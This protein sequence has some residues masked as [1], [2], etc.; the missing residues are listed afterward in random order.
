MSATQLEY[1][2]KVPRSLVLL[3]VFW[4]VGTSVAMFLLQ[5][6]D[7]QLFYQDEQQ[8]EVFFDSGSFAESLKLYVDPYV[9]SGVDEVYVFHFWNPECKCDQSNS[10]HVRKLVADYS[11]NTMFFVVSA[12]EHY[13]AYLEQWKDVLPYYRIEFVDYQALNL[14]VDLPATPA[15]AVIQSTGKLNYF[16]PYSEGGICLPN[17]EGIVEGV[18]DSILMGQSKY[19]PFTTGYGCYCPWPTNKT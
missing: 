7:L 4:V 3:F 8:M 13:S 17:E 5:G 2:T 1:E 15:A 19:Y 9:S 10:L 6:K 11:K 16:G 12:K 18:L 14:Q